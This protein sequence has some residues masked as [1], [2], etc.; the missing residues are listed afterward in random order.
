MLTLR[1]LN[2]RRVAAVGRKRD[3]V[4]LVWILITVSLGLLSI[5][6]SLSHAG[7]GDATVMIA[8]T[9]YVQ[10]VATLQPD[11]ALLAG[12]DWIFKTHMFFGMTLFLIFPFTRLV[13]IWSVPIG[14]LGRAYQIVRRR[15]MVMN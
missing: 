5:P 3:L 7:N 2:N 6:F 10:S 14:Y 15:R 1:R 13:H 8:L 12:V 4:T 9:H 11:P